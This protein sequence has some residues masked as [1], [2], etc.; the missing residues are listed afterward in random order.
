[1]KAIA[2][3]VCAMGSKEWIMAF[4]IN[5]PYAKAGKLRRLR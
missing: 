1:V 3:Y 4:I 2:G 5:H